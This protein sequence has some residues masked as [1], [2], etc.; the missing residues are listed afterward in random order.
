MPPDGFVPPPLD[1]E[2]AGK[3]EIKPEPVLPEQGRAIRY[4]APTDGPIDVDRG[5]PLDSPQS[6]RV[7]GLQGEM[8]EPAREL[9]TYLATSNGYRGLSPSLQKFRTAL[10]RPA[11]ELRDGDIELL[12]AR[13]IRIQMAYDDLQ[14]E[15]RRDEAPP[16]D[17]RLRAPMQVLLQL[18]GPFLQT[19]VRGLELYEQTD[20]DRRTLAEEL[21]LKEM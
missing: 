6:D 16:E 3:P 12:Y 10:D 14:E 18:H 11:A 5:A 19:T 2:E 21:A 8:L 1:A 4:V 15:I 17:R 9:E 13:G 20:R 7:A